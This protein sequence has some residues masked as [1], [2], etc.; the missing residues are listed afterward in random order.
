MLYCQKTLWNCPLSLILTHNIRSTVSRT[1]IPTVKLRD[2]QLHGHD[3]VS[4][5]VANLFM[6][7]SSSKGHGVSH[8]VIS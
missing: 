2:F 5:I 8:Q 7:D 1:S 4:P 3:P 6:E